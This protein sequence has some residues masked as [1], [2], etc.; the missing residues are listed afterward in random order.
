MAVRNTESHGSLFHGDDSRRTSPEG[1][2]LE[3]GIDVDLRDGDERECLLD[4]PPELQDSKSNAVLLAQGHKAAMQRSFSPL[5]ALGLGFSIT[6][7]WVGYLSCFGQNLAY[8]GPN[9]VIFGL[10]LAAVIQWT[11]SLGL[12]EIASC[13]P[14]SGGQYHFVFILAPK[15]SKRF[16]AFVVGWMN[17]LGWSVAL[18]S[19]VSVVVASITGLVAFWDDT[20]LVTQWG[21]YVIYLAV[22][23]LSLSPLFLGPRLIPQILQASLAFSVTGLII[24]FCLLLALR[25][26]SQPLSFL[27]ITNGTS[28]WGIGAAWMLGLGNSMYAF[29]ST[30]AVLHIAEEMSH[31]E[32]R[33]PQVVNLTMTIGFMT[34]FPLLL[35][36]MLSMADINAVLQSP[37]PYAEVFRQITDSKIV[38][39]I[40]MCWITI[41]LFSCLIG[42]WVTCGRLAWAFARDRGLPYPDFFSHISERYGFPVRTTILALGFCSAYGILYIASTT[43]F[44]SI[45][46]SAVLFSNITYASPQGLVAARGRKKTLPEH[47]FDLGRLGYVCNFLSPIFV[48]I[49]GV[50]ICFPP[51]LPVTRQNANYTPV[52]L[53]GFVVAILGFWVTIG[54]KFEGPKIDWEVLRSVKVT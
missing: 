11:I 20:F 39:T 21:S 49:V 12:S 22:A 28:G 35:V 9:S 45:I 13:F 37:L 38:T 15:R 54:K 18:S 17:I 16:A 32:R 6:N 5:A 41:I 51:E 46:T 2:G 27:L 14:S 53:V 36:M 26:Q 42:Q 43:A 25:K 29:S 24:I 4:R 40:M 10:L 31:P 30:D 48:I 8:A 23:V 44:N 1:H 3:T 34:A 47:P 19:G 33:L 7:S 52:V 50:L